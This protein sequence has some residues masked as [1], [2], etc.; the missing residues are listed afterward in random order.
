M[1]SLSSPSVL[2]IEFCPNMGMGVAVGEG[3]G[4][5]CR[6]LSRQG[7]IAEDIHERSQVE[8]S[9]VDARGL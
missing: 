1:S 9:L 8:Y 3:E 6:Y 4:A 5:I 2:D 7:K